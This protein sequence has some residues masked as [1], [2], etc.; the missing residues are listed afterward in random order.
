MNIV[1]AAQMREIDRRAIE[2]YGIPGVVLM[3]NAGLRLV[4]FIRQLEC[5]PRIVVVAGKGNNGGDGFVAA[6]HLNGEK[7][8]SVWTTADVGDYQG[9]ALINLHILHKLQIPCVNL[10][11]A[12]ALARL[13]A[14]LATADLV[15][16]ALLGTGVTRDVDPFYAQVI[17]CINET[18]VPVLAVDIP[19][20]ISADTG[21]ALGHAVRA[22]FTVTFALPKRGL[23]L[24][25]GAAHTGE[26]EVADIGIP[27][28]LLVGHGLGLLTPERVRRL[29][30]AR[31]ANAH[32]GTFGSALLVAGSQGMSGAATLCA[33]AALRGGCG[34]VFVATPRS[35]QPIVATQVAEAITLPL[36]ET[37]EGHLLSEALP[38][39]REKWQSCQSL[40]IGPGLT[41]N[42]D[43]LPLLAGILSECPLPVVLDADALNLLAKHPDVL[44]KR[45]APTVLTPHPGEAARLL[46]CSIAEVEANRLKAVEQL[47][48]QYRSTVILKGAHTL[49]A[50][51]QEDTML[52]VTGNSGMATAGSGDVLTGLLASL[53]AQGLD[54][55]EAAWTAI[56][57][58]GLAA[59]LATEHGS[60]ASLIASD[61][62]NHISLAYLETLKIHM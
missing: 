1:T 11:E 43:S 51:P 3:E 54:M 38:L 46:A 31:L 39:L 40:A 23:L 27:P 28:S 47:C 61:I 44:D 50:T 58:H 16:D 2:E 48:I 30:P 18:T 9:D 5:G 33:H 26:L 13:E 57:L 7:D 22:N 15:V 8:V 21:T 4:E 45:T 10:R 12:E 34:L 55:P 49:V 25:P 60:E 24:F 37:K 53:L 17:R 62:I 6:R 56:Y 52:N 14:K 20:G 29:V 59:D 42:E 32:K 36:P 35:I 19:S 41:Q